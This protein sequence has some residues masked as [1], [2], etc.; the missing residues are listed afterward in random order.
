MRS[1]GRIGIVRDDQIISFLTEIAWASFVHFT[2]RSYRK[3]SIDFGSE[4]L[5]VLYPQSFRYSFLQ[6]YDCRA[7]VWKTL[8]KM[9]PALDNSLFTTQP[10]ASYLFE[11]PTSSDPS[12]SSVVSPHSRLSRKHNIPPLLN[13]S[14]SCFTDSYPNSVKSAR[15]EYRDYSIPAPFS[16]PISITPFSPPTSSGRFSPPL[17][18][19]RTS[20]PI[21]GKR[22]SSPSLKAKPQL[23]LPSLSEAVSALQLSPVDET[24]PLGPAKHSRERKRESDGSV[25]SHRSGDSMPSPQESPQSPVSV[26][27]PSVDRAS[28]RNLIGED[29]TRCRFAEVSRSDGERV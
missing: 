1:S 22:L 17:S 10:E 26:A 24:S 15:E 28:Q 20:P 21:S 29:K 6:Q 7:E 11:E 23:H 12:L 18:G 14:A 2:D 5:C 3:E 4:Y 27:I 25:F 19:I 16:P 13:G 9:S 8:L